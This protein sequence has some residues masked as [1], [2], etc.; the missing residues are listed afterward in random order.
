M[1]RLNRTP[2]LPL[3]TRGRLV[4]TSLAHPLLRTILTSPLVG[5]ARR[6]VSLHTLRGFGGTQ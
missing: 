5:E 4:A 1:T 3:P 2:S 6:G